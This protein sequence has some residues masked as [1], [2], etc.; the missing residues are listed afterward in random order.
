[1]A[2]KFRNTAVKASTP[3]QIDVKIDNR[4]C[5]RGTKHVECKLKKHIFV[6]ANSGDRKDWSSSKSVMKARPVEAGLE[7]TMELEMLAAVPNSTAIGSI[8]ANYYVL[9]AK[10]VVDGCLCCCGDNHPVVERPI[11]I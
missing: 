3:I 10:A 5:K 7:G 8:V 6:Q 2:V 4:K 1:M 9:R 11:F